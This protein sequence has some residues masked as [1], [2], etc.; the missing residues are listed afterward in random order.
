MHAWYKT[1][2][3][4]IAIACAVHNFDYLPVYASGYSTVFIV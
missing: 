4:P 2:I 1:A 3:K